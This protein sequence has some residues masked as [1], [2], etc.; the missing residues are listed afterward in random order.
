MAPDNC[1]PSNRLGPNLTENWRGR[2]DHQTSF[3]ATP[4][5]RDQS[6]P[7]ST[8]PHPP[9]QSSTFPQNTSYPPPQVDANSAAKK[10][11]HP[12]PLLVL[13]KYVPSQ[14]VVSSHASVHGVFASF[15]WVV[16]VWLPLP[17]A[18]QLPHVSA[19]PGADTKRAQFQN[20]EKSTITTPNIMVCP[21]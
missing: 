13:R 5:Q 18:N 16:H 9:Y 2:I 19:G 6:P 3:E 7:P 4:K 14:Q 20:Q 8:L 10:C 15:S 12:G 21:Q 11:T 17:L 1:V